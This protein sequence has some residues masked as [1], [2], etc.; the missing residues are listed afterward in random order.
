MSAAPSPRERSRRDT[1]NR[2]ELA[3]T[4]LALEQGFND[5]TVDEICDRADVA[6]STFFKYFSSRDAAI[7]GRELQILEGEDASAVLSAH[8]GFLP[9]GVFELIFASVGHAHVHTDVARARQELTR[10]QPDARAVGTL[11]LVDSA[12]L[13]MSG[14]RD[15]LIEHPQHARLPDDPTAEASLA[16]NAAYAAIS[17]MAGGWMAA[18]GDITASA[19][20]FD[21]ALDDLRRVAGH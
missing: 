20:E 4:S 7:L 13:L 9:R 19:E 5:V 12:A 21:A 15:W 8:A 14:V 17:T 6:R 2:I 1:E 3:A 18:A 10:T 11:I 16:T